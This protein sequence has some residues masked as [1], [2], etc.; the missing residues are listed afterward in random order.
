MKR[1]KA[2]CLKVELFHRARDE[3]GFEYRK[4]ISYDKVN[5]IFLINSIL[6]M[7]EYK[8]I[9]CL[10]IWYYCRYF[11]WKIIKE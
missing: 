5:L 1:G 10:E 3:Y 11:C 6:G 9:N 7:K 2:S 4:T 8:I